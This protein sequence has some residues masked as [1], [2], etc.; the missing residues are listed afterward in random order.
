MSKAMHCSKRHTEPN[1]RS[2]VVHAHTHARTEVF[3]A[4]H[5]KGTVA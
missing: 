4:L 2:K 1:P 3:G 5:L